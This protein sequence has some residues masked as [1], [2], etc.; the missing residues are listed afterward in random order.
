MAGKGR[1]SGHAVW[2]TGSSWR[3]HAWFNGV[4]RIGKEDWAMDAELRAIEW[5]GQQGR[6]P[7]CEVLEDLGRL[8]AEY[9][10]LFEQG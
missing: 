10:S 6:D 8:R 3:W 7:L 4:S 5:I 2:W 9:P 1:S